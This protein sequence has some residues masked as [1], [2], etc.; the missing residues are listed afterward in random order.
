MTGVSVRDVDV[1]HITLLI[2]HK[3]VL[4]FLGLK[5]HRCIWYLTIDFPENRCTDETISAEYLKRQGRL[6]IPGPYHRISSIGEEARAL[7]SGRLLF[8]MPPESLTTFERI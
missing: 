6:P 3:V 4:T 7:H 8:Y 2:S 1:C 5:V